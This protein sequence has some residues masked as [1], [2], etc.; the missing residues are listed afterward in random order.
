MTMFEQP[1][2]PAPP[3]P[4]TLPP[5]PP[6]QVPTTR[7]EPHRR[8]I[9]LR[10]AIAAI[11]IVL[12]A[13]AS[14][15][16]YRLLAA[17]Q[18][19]AGASLAGVAPKN[20]IAYV[21]VHLDA[22]GD[23]H[24]KLGAFLAHFPAFGTAS[25]LD[26]RLTELYDKVL[27]RM[28]NGKLSWTTDVAP[29]FGGTVG[30]AVTRLPK[31]P[32]GP[33]T[34]GTVT[35]EPGI[36]IVASVKDQ[37]GATAWMQKL[38]ADVDGTP[39]T[40]T[41]RGTGVTSI[42]SGA[43]AVTDKT[44]IVG[45]TSSV[46]QTL[47]DGAAGGLGGTKAFAD[48][49]GTLTGTNLGTM[50]VDVNRYAD[51]LTAQA[52]A[53]TVALCGVTDSLPGWIAGSFAADTNALLGHSALPHVD[54]GAP[55]GNTS[56]A[57]IA[58]IPS[59]AL[60]VVD[61]HELGAYIRSAVER[62]EKCDASSMGSE[63]QK[64]IDALGGWDKL[65]GWIGETAVVLDRDGSQPTG[66]LLIV[67]KDRAA[68][69]NFALQVKNMAA[70]AGGLAPTDAPYAG[71]TISTYAIPGSDQQISY[72]FAD[73]YVVVGAGSWVKKVL[74][75]TDAT[76]LEGN[77]RFTTALSQA[78]A[79]HTSLVYADIAGLRDWVEGVLP[80]GEAKE[81]AEYVGP[82]LKPFEALVTTTRTGADLDRTDAVLTVK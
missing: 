67:P 71:T 19:N 53:S 12:V 1:T 65:T 66:G 17:T 28:S 13:T 20:A 29:W 64:G 2:P 31:L 42:G 70:L 45:D 77:A 4:P 22:P 23:Q 56:S 10:W 49:A 74:D 18:T 26:A 8:G 72:A 44:L 38:T 32:T 9:G 14:Y 80:A 34:S 60:A 51:W 54:N 36:V 52:P 47:D 6:L 41:Y 39:S 27:A 15:A 3:A 24:Q 30:V 11:A 43:Y 55:A 79:E 73:G 35:M 58:H 68:A 62:F 25:D 61:E 40:E 63:I 33:S 16:G 78:A 57:L 46:K 81:Y 5:P 48:A 7:V 59:S 82:Y 50:Y 75:T 21:E 37:A 69:E 76:A